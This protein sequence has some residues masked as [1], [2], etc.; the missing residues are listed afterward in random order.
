MV[1]FTV[2]VF[3]F[4]I[5]R[6]G[7]LVPGRTSDMYSRMEE[8][9]LTTFPL[10]ETRTSPCLMPAFWAGDPFSTSTTSAP[11]VV[12]SPI[13]LAICGVISCADTPIQPRTT[14]PVFSML[15]TTPMTRLT[16]IAKPMPTLLRSGREWR[17]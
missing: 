3:P 4:R 12:S 11:L 13:A 1:T 16:G 5:R 7:T 2:R 17:Y 6:T 10:M 8:A 9:S 14:F 15:R